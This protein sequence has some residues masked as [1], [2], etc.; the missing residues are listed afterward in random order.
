MKRIINEISKDIEDIEKLEYVLKQLKLWFMCKKN[1]INSL[2]NHEILNLEK[3][4]LGIDINTKNKYPEIINI[5]NHYFELIK[6]PNYELSDMLD[7]KVIKK[8]V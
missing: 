4:I 7:E 2:P 8:L 3:L 5:I 6:I 1:Y